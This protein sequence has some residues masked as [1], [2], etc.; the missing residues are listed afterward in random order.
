MNEM[1]DQIRAVV[2]VVV[3]LVIL[4]AWGHF[5]KPPI[6]PPLPAQ[7]SAQEATS[8]TP[9]TSASV[10]RPAQTADALAAASLVKAEAANEKSVVI[11]S[12]LYVVEFSNRGGVA[13]SLIKID[14]LLNGDQLRAANRGFVRSQSRGRTCRAPSANAG[15]KDTTVDGFATGVARFEFEGHRFTAL[16]R[17]DRSDPGG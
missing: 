9:N 2:F 4:F 8:Q 10:A 17:L 6:Q 12:P 15:G 5:Y 14:R 11:E 16:V 3:A 13:R 1:G 7:A